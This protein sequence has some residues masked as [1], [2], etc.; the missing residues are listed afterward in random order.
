MRRYR[1]G[2]EAAFILLCRDASGRPVAPDACPTFDIYSASGKPLAGKGAPV[3]DPAAAPGLFVGRALLGEDFAEG[4][5]TAVFR[6]VDGSGAHSSSEAFPFRVMP[7]GD[8]SGQVIALCDYRRPQANYAVQ[9][10]T[11]GRLYKGK[12]ARL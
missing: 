2:E 8:P 5:H 12:G 11:S 6:W 1:L 10:R 3:L 9:Q 4:E 7:G